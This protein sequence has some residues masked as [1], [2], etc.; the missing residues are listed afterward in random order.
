MKTYSMSDYLYLCSCLS[1]IHT[2]IR[3]TYSPVGLTYDDKLSSPSKSIYSFVSLID[4]L[5]S[6]MGLNIQHAATALQLKDHR[7][8]WQFAHRSL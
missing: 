6:P 3:K 1:K 2:N 7:M 5:V 8:L 4:K